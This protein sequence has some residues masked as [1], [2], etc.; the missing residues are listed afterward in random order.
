MPCS[1]NFILQGFQKK[2]SLPHNARRPTGS[3]G[4]LKKNVIRLVT[5]STRPI[6]RGVISKTLCFYEPI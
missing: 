5:N 1:P 2:K 3:Q 6:Q 4:L